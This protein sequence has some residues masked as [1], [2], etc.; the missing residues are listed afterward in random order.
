MSQCLHVS[1][2]PQRENGTNGEQQLPFVSCKWKTELANSVC[3]L[4]MELE[5]EVCFPWS[6]KD[7][8]Q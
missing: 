8:G 2:I 1:G 5:K 7:D 4:Q 3:L 6:A